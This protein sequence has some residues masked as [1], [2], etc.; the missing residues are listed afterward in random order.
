[1]Q[2]IDY[3]LI[4][5]DFDGTLARSDGTVSEK[6][7]NAITRYVA[8]GGRFAISTGRL[9]A[10]IISRAKELG[11]VGA[12]CCAQG[13]VIV[14]IQSEKILLEGRIPNDVAV[15]VCE[16]MQARG[17]HIHVYDLWEYYSNMDDDYLAYYEG[18]VKTKAVLVTDKPMSQFVKESG[19]RPFKILAM[20]DPQENERIRLDLEKENF[21]GCDVTRSSS[22]LVEV[23]NAAFSKGTSV[24][25]LAKQ[26]GVDIQK[27]IAI[28]DQIND[29]SMIQTAAL[30][31]AVKNA[32]ETL[33][34]HAITLDKTNDEDAVAAVI[35]EYG[36][37]NA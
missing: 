23:G 31:F 37:T 5:T 2:K 35:E 30:G 14:D 18:V 16:A 9:P 33:K 4:V 25:F 28:G 12:V 36:Y 21:V 19:M 26:Y 8:D 15:A 7:K 11:L 6:T 1:M 3:A 24:Q 29:L 17:L 10:A 13:S 34:A 20:V 22:L 32:D 27:T